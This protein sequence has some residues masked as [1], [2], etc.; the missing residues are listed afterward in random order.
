MDDLN[1]TIAAALEQFRNETEGDFAA[2]AVPLSDKASL[3]W[4]YAS[5]NLNRRYT[6]LTVKS[7]RGIAGTALRTERAV[8]LDRHRYAADLRKEDSPLFTAERLE[9]AAAVPI[10]LA[11]GFKGVLLLGCRSPRNFDTF[12][13]EKLYEAARR[14]SL[15]FSQSPDNPSVS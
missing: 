6:Q 10:L 15:V 8:V 14:F 7:G 5:G 9:D 3:H 1:P 13:V 11:N 12:F 4:N 2:F